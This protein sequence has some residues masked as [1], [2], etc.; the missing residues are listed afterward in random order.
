MKVLSHLAQEVLEQLIRSIQEA[1]AL[2]RRADL[3]EEA[4]ELIL[5]EEFGDPARRE[6]IIDVD[7]ELVI[8]DLSIS[9]DEEQL[10]AGDS[11]LLEHALNISLQV[12]HVVV[13]CHHDS[14]DIVAEDEAG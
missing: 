7:E 6:E 1:S 8:G 10:V 11:S 13:R 2:G 12:V 5:R 3:T 14:D 9:K 4:I